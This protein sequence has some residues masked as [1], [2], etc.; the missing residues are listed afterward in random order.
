[1]GNIDPHRPTH[2]LEVNDLVFQERV[3]PGDGPFPVFL[4]LHG[5]TG[6]ENSMWIFAS[7]LPENAL[8]LSPR[9]LY[10]SPLGGFSWYPKLAKAWPVLADFEPAIK[11]L[12][13][14]LSVEY[15][16]EG[17]FSQLRMLGFSQGAAF[18]YSF[19]LKR[20]KAVRSLAGLSG[21]VPEGAASLIA[22]LPLKDL[23]VF[24]AH[25]IRDPL[26]PVERARLGVDVLQ[27]AG[28]QVAYCEHEAGHKL[29]ADCFRSLQI[30]FQQN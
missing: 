30:F 9:G 7:R 17:D 4:M 2:R 26:V 11:V 1:M 5:W 13:E 19:A 24:I 12:S 27:R 6:D 10:Q 29:N 23:A 16:P 21:F 8:L 15:F 22:G 18:V 20:P 3:P 14:V 25:G 28:A